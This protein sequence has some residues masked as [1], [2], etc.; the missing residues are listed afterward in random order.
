VGRRSFDR[1][2]KRKEER[3]FW[4][5]YDD[6]KLL[7]KVRKDYFDRLPGMKDCAHEIIVSGQETPKQ[8]AERIER[9]ILKL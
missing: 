7:D 4:K 3:D 9:L 6:N 2:K 8:L 5:G 1:E